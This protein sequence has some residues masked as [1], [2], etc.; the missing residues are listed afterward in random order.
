MRIEGRWS[1][2]KG[3]LQR[4]DSLEG[5]VC[6]AGI[7]MYG[8]VDVIANDYRVYQADPMTDQDH[9]HS[10]LRR[11]TCTGTRLLIF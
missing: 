3:R 10:P 4:Q 7:S 11:V 8:R 5:R 6:P 2:G 1:E 9:P